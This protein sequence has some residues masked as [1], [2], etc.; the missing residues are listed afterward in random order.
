MKTKYAIIICTIIVIALLALQQVSIRNNNNS[1]NDL[2]NSIN[3]LSNKLDSIND[4]KDSLIIRIDT[5]KVKIIELEKRYETIRDSI[6]TQSVD[7]DCITFSN[8]VS[9]YNNRLSSSNNSSAIKN[10]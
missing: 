6:V 7:S 5:T 9:N 2:I 4:L 10:Y 1:T 8:Y 3:K